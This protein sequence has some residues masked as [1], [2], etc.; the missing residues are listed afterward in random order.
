MS[1]G[2]HMMRPAHG[3]VCWTELATDDMAAAKEFYSA[4]FGWT[5]KTS[6]TTGM[7]YTEFMNDGKPIG[8]MFQKTP[9]MAQ[10]P[11]H[12]GSYVAVENV[13]ESAAKAT[14]LGATMV[15]PLMDIPNVGRFC[16]IKD[17]TG[18]VISM[19]T[20]GGSAPQ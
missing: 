13:D 15:V 2:E 1:D 4:L 12:W 16:A 10:V 11:T 5:M 20:L 3:S 19:I 17:P 9:E 6:D 8:G 14:E 18:G 7:Q